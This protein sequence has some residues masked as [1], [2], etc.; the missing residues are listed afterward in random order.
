MHR[1]T[2]P[3]PPPRGP[4]DGRRGHRRQ[5]PGP[6]VAH[7]LAVHLRGRAP[8]GR[9]APRGAVHAG[10]RL[11]GHAGRGPRGRRRRRPLPRHLRRRHLQPADHRDGRHPHRPR[12][13]GQPAQLAAPDPP[14]RARDPGRG[15]PVAVVLPRG[16]RGARAAPDPRPPPGHAASPPPGAGRGRTHHRHRRAPHRLHARPPPHRHRA[17]PHARELV[18]SARD[19]VVA[20]QSGQQH[21]RRRGPA[22]RQ[23][24]PV[25]RRR[26]L[27]RGRRRLDRGRHVVVA[28]PGRP[29]GTDARRGRRSRA[30]PLRH[31]VDARAGEPDPVLRGPRGPAHHRREGRGDLHQ[32]RRGRRPSAG[33]RARRADRRRTVRG[34]APRPRAGLDPAVGALRDRGPRR[35]RRRGGHRRGP[36]PRLPRAPD[37]VTPREGRRRQPH[38]ARPPRRGV[39]GPHLLGR[40]V[41]V[42]VPEPALPGHHPGPAALPGPPPPRGPPPGPGAGPDRRPVPVAVRQRRHRADAHPAVEPALG[43]LDARQLAPPAP[44]RPRGGLERVA[45]PTGQRRLP[46]HA[47]ARHRAARRAGPLLDRPGHARA[48]TTTAST[49]GA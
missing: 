41:R 30:G 8:R 12:E 32:P 6:G 16:R 40:A 37:R 29:G 31:L 21:Q 43:P 15:S 23:P 36:P 10:Q 19:P 13:P 38:G 1:C 11:P 9:G 26:G 14:G 42:P 2:R 45:V 7:R 27:E 25:G 44:R 24:P 46:L 4:T 33:V 17:G 48:P 35:L 5:R 22:A 49:S 18:G 28:R 47:G 3:P 39:P 20:R 34:P